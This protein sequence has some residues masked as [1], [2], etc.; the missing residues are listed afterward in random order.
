MSKINNEGSTIE[1]FT[2]RHGLLQ[3]TN[4][5]NFFP[6]ADNSSPATDLPP[7]NS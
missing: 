6:I 7:S 1:A 2:I 3:L 4:K 5:P